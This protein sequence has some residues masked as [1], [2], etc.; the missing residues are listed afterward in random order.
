MEKKSC[1][2]DYSE[3]EQM[4]SS[5]FDENGFCVMTIEQRMD[6]KEWVEF[7]LLANEGTVLEIEEIT[8]GKNGR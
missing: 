1:Q 6:S 7:L 5:Y 8:Y 3:N 2:F 4:F